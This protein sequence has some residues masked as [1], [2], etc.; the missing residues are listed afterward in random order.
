MRNL[1][2]Y[3]SKKFII[4]LVMALSMSMMIGLVSQNMT[5][6]E[7]I[8]TVEMCG[9]L[10][11]DPETVKSLLLNYDD[12]FEEDSMLYYDEH[13]GKQNSCTAWAVAYGLKSYQEGLEHGYNPYENQAGRFSPS[14]I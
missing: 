11:E 13:Q 6:A 9:C 14:Y 5:M 12:I 3:K 2:Y 1:Q 10:P 8:E 4:S 7:E